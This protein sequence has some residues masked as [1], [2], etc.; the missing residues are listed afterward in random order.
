[1]LRVQDDKVTKDDDH[2]GGDVHVEGRKAQ[3]SRQYTQKSED[4]VKGGLSNVS[5]L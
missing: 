3:H 5:H 1:M 4:G 2:G